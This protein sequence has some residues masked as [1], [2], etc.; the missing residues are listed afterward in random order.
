MVADF[1][2]RGRQKA[3]NLA[4]GSMSTGKHRDDGMGDMVED[5]EVL[6]ATRSG[7]SYWLRLQK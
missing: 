5:D 2:G 7:V 1:D 4:E 3:E 6:A